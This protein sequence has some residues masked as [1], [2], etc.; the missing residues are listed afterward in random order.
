MSTSTHDGLPQSED[1]AGKAPLL[2]VTVLNYNYARYLPQC[3]DSILRQTWTDFEVILINDCSPDN[4]LDVIQPYLVDPRVKLVDHPQN[5]GFM[6]SL[7]EGSEMSRGKY[8]TVVSADD[9]CLSDRTFETL[10]L[11]LEADPEA[12]FAYSA[13]GYYGDD[14]IRTWL[15]RPVEKTCVR[16]GAEEYLDLLRL[17][18]HMMHSGVIIRKTAYYAVGGYD[19]TARYSDLIMWLMLC[20][21]GKVAYSSDELY[22][23]RKHGSNMSISKGHIIYGV[24]EDIYGIEK[25][26]PAMCGKPGI[27]E[28]LRVWALKRALTAPTMG[29]AFAS[30]PLLAW[31]SYWCA[32]RINP[33]LTVFQ[34]RTLILITRTFLG[35]RGYTLLRSLL[36]RERPILATA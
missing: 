12:A 10:I 17:G 4:S 31:Y 35:Y 18:N 16:S 26:F 8:I 5:K 22:A 20:G 9:Y 19:P 29:Y 25:S 27:T 3:L 34:A 1:S 30:R 15:S 28:D 13:H 2:S 6:A 33:K 32:I 23:Y 11:M 36:K 21:Q 7:I 14:G 24:R